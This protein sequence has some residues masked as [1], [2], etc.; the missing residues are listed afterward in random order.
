MLIGRIL[1]NIDALILDEKQLVLPNIKFVKLEENTTSYF[2]SRGHYDA[3]DVAPTAVP[4]IALQI[5]IG[6]S[7]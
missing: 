6:I 1:G 4:S 7:V 3:A 2:K 5:L